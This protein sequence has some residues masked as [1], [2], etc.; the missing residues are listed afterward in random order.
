[1]GFLLSFS[2]TDHRPP[3]TSYS[4]ID[5]NWLL[6]HIWNILSGGY[7]S[8]KAIF[9]EVPSKLQNLKQSKQLNKMANRD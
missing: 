8:L 1:L 9:K 5:I 6:G 4:S 7:T 3:A 2:G